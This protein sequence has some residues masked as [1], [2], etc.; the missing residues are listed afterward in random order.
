MSIRAESTQNLSDSKR[1]PG[2]FYLEVLIGKEQRRNLVR[3][4]THAHTVSESFVHV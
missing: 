4:H 2:V 1:L 3:T